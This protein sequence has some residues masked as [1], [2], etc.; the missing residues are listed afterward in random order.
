M[1]LSLHKPQKH[2]TTQFL[3]KHP[4]RL[5][6][7]NIATNGMKVAGHSKCTTEKRSLDFYDENS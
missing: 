4:I 1:Q 2:K 6:T 3:I 7:S 5:K